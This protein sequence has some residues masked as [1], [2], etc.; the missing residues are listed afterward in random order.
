MRRSR[1]RDERHDIALSSVSR[2]NMIHYYRSMNHPGMENYKTSD[3]LDVE[4]EE[5]M[6]YLGEI[7]GY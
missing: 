4:E 5:D 6:K 3:E 7:G 2:D 1:E